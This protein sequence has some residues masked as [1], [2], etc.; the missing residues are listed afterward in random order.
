MN[1]QEQISRIHE[2]MLINE[3]DKIKKIVDREFDNFFDNLELI[4]TEDNIHHYNWKTKDKKKIFERNHWGRF[5][6]WGCDEWFDLKLIGIIFDL[7]Y[8]EFEHKLLEY[9]NNKY[10]SQFGEEN[11]LKDI[12]SESC[13]DFDY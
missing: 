10:K 12:R 3:S 9:L 2:M 4:K 8:E 5:W 1:L 11:P 7:T 13:Y 6:I